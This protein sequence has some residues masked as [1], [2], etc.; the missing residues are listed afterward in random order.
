[1]AGVEITMVTTGIQDVVLAMT[2]V[3]AVGEDIDAATDDAV[4]KAQKVL[5][6]TSGS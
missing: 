1:M 2:F 5:A 3:G 6:G 4:T